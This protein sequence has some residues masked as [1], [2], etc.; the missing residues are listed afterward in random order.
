MLDKF[1]LFLMTAELGYFILLMLMG[2]ALTILT[3]FNHSALDFLNK[4]HT[5]ILWPVAPYILALPLNLFGR[6]DYV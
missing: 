5:V 3:R 2:I 6:A 4:Y 1:L